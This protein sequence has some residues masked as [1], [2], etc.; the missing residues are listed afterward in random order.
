MDSRADLLTKLLKIVRALDDAAYITYASKGLLRRARKSLDAGTLVQLAETGERRVVLMVDDQTVAMAGNGPLKAE[1][2]CPAPGSCVHV[3][4]ACLRLDA[5]AASHADDRGEEETPSFPAPASAKPRDAVVA[6]TAPSGADEEVIAQWLQISTDGLR[7][8]AGSEAYRNAWRILDRQEPIVRALEVRFKGERTCRLIADAGLDGVISNA[9]PKEHKAYAVAAVLALQAA[10]GNIP[11]PDVRDGDDGTGID[12]S[13]LDDIQ[14]LLEQMMR[15][16]LNHLSPVFLQRFHQLAI[17][18]RAGGLYRPAKELD[19]CARIVERL[20]Q[21][22]AGADIR[23]LFDRLAALYALTVAINNQLPRAPL[24]LVGTARSTYEAMDSISLVGMG[25]YPWETDSGY[26]G[27]TGLFW[28]PELKCYFSWSDSRP[29]HSRAGF[30]PRQRYQDESPWSGG[31]TLETLCH[32]SFVLENPR[33]NS[34][35]RLSAHQGCRVKTMQAPID[36]ALSAAPFATWSDLFESMRRRHKIGLRR[37]TPLDALCLIQPRKWHRPAFDETRQRLLIALEDREG[38][39]L[40]LDL[41]FSKW[42]E[43][44]IYYLESNYAKH[45]NALLFG[46]YPQRPI[47]GFFPLS[48]ISRNFDSRI[49]DLL[50]TPLPTKK[51][52][53]KGRVLEKIKPFIPLLE[54]SRHDSIAI[55]CESDEIALFLSPLDSYLL[56]IAESGFQIIGQGIQQPSLDL[57]GAGLLQLSRDLAGLDSGADILMTRYHYL[58]HLDAVNSL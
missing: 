29:T 58:L 2:S 30:S 11:A 3:I 55:S 23:G 28:A 6:D 45:K 15:V 5:L 9:P 43:S 44:A 26:I 20:I 31:K 50:F 27:L 12:G 16:G 24:D 19:G 39:N 56:R 22:H 49:L 38:E 34:D 14:D 57:A 25:A 53:W 17:L 33:I 51:I 4:M 32:S 1:C 40:M 52:N 47:G 10:N 21:R 35:R 18:C 42:T 41:P 54:T 13:L 37:G 7:K 36:P 48:L 46:Y 8:W